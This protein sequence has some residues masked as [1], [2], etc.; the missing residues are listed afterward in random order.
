MAIV[1][2]A[3]LYQSVTAATAKMSSYDDTV[4]HPSPASSSGAVDSF[5]GTPHTSLTAFSP[6]DVRAMKS[7]P[8][9]LGDEPTRSSQ[10][11]PFVSSGTQ[12]GGRLSARASAFQPSFEVTAATPAAPSTIMQPSKKM[13]A[14][15]PSDNVEN[16]GGAQSP[17]G[18]LDTVN[19]AHFGAFT[20]DSNTSRVLKVTGKD[21][22][23]IFL[24][25]VEATKKVSYSISIARLET[26]WLLLFVISY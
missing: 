24:P 12:I 26:C 4:Y 8:V 20:T 9:N 19:C 14:P 18:A 6:E 1:R 5:G 7:A 13:H 21:A 23:A 17:N 16:L 15:K 11:D 25:L 2:L 3:S 22:V 10:Q